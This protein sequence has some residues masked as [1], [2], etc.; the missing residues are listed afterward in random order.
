MRTPRT[1]QIP[2]A[3]Y[4]PAADSSPVPSFSYQE[5]QQIEGSSGCSALQTEANHADKSLLEP[6]AASL[7][8]VRPRKKSFGTALSNPPGPPRSPCP[9]ASLPVSTFSVQC[10][11]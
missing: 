5:V 8:P 9:L 6:K 1:P 7:K 4:Q 2:C 3:L 11:G 10:D